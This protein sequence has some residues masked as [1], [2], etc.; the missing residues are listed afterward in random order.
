VKS[1]ILE[2]GGRL[3][4]FSACVVLLD[5]HM[6]PL[7]AAY[8]LHPRLP[9]SRGSDRTGSHHAEDVRRVARRDVRVTKYMRDAGKVS[10][11]EV[12]ADWCPPPP[13]LLEYIATRPSVLHS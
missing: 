12:A 13:L 6:M 1:K 4:D 11:D 7:G 5:H 2:E 3:L 8:V 9:P 10:Q